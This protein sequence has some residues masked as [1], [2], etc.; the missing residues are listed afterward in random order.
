MMIAPALTALAPRV[1]WHRP[2]R[3]DGS[4][5][6]D[7]ATILRD[8]RE[9][10]D[11]RTPLV[12]QASLPLCLFR[13]ERWEDFDGG[14]YDWADYDPEGCYPPIKVLIGARWRPRLF[15]KDGNHRVHFWRRYGYRLAPAW[16]LDYPEASDA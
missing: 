9:P 3:D 15:I 16:V 4:A 1:D 5:Y 6:V 14:S 12:Y 8:Y 2:D 10:G 13:V 11:P 7:A